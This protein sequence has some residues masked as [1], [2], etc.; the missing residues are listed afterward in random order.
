MSSSSS[1]HRSPRRPLSASDEQ[2]QRWDEAAR[3]HGLRWST[4]ARRMLDLH[5]RVM[6]TCD[7]RR[8]HLVCTLERG[9]SGPHYTG[10][11]DE[12]DGHE[13]LDGE[14]FSDSDIRSNGRPDIRQP[15][16]LLR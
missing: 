2:W 16:R 4:W 15:R 6:V 3:A 14:F 7:K 13:Q 11:S 5:T 8:A 10:P 1:G 9:H 12:L